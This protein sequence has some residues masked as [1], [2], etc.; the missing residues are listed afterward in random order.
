MDLY[1]GGLAG[2]EPK[3]TAKIKDSPDIIK[4]LFKEKVDFTLVRENQI[5]IK[6]TMT[7]ANEQVFLRILKSYKIFMDQLDL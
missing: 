6:A 1:Y 7:Y 3:E 5:A 4:G 2:D